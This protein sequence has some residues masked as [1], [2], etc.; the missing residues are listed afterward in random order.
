MITTSG[1]V[2]ATT[3]DVS[4][5]RNPAALLKVT[6]ITVKSWFTFIYGFFRKIMVTL[7]IE[8]FQPKTSFRL[9]YKI[10][11]TL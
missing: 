6:V 2:V 11:T 9:N 3:N 10:T 1:R 4:V 5:F 8:P 7:T